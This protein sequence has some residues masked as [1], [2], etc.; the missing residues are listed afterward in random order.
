M[1]G[2][3]YNRNFNTF[4]GIRK[5]LQPNVHS[6]LDERIFKWG[7]GDYD[8]EGYFI[9]TKP[10]YQKCV[11]GKVP[12]YKINNDGF[13]SRHFRPL[14]NESINVLVG[15]CSWTFGEGVPEEYIWPTTL[16][17]NI[18]NKLNKKVDLYNTG[19][20]GFGIDLIIK[21]LMSFIQNNGA[22]DYIFMLLPDMGRQVLFNE[23]MNQYFKFFPSLEWLENNK[24][25]EQQFKYTLSFK[26]E[27]N[28]LFHSSMIHLF[29][30]FCQAK[31]I[32]LFWTSWETD[33]CKI[34]RELNFKNY[35]Y[36]EHMLEVY[37]V[38]QLD[39][40]NNIH[41]N[42]LLENPDN[43]EYWTKAEDGGHPGIVVHNYIAEKFMSAF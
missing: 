16:K 42:Y 14:S 23:N 25:D 22:P 11:D 5:F 21:N 31:N 13:R 26:Y 3:S 28:L 12:T 6:T 18:E 15:G 10:W 38:T 32:K 33:D 24:R 41:F 29:E 36:E 7:I 9:V 35:I 43:M 19:F 30:S 27:N 39:D 8:E 20:M 1:P 37:R 34:Y 4:E 2:H 40:Y 17:N